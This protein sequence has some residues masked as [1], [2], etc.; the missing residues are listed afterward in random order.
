MKTLFL[1]ILQFG[2][3]MTY[4][5]AFIVYLVGVLLGFM[6]ALWIFMLVLQGNN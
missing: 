3:P 4:P 5:I 1:Q 6:L 2:L